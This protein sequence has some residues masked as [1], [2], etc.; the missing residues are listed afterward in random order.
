MKQV[1]ICDTAPDNAEL[2]ESAHAFQ[3]AMDVVPDGE[4]LHFVDCQSVGMF[5]E[6]LQHR[7][8]PLRRSHDF[9]A[10]FYVHAVDLR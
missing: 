7:L 9:F 10:G 4:R 1:G 6:E 5:D 8:F 2:A 3:T